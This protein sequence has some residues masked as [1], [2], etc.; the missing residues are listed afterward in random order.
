MNIRSILILIFTIVGNL[1]FGQERVLVVRISSD[2][3]KITTENMIDL[4]EN[5]TSL[6]VGSLEDGTGII[7]LDIDKKALETD[8]LEDYKIKTFPTRIKYNV[9]CKIAK[10]HQTLSAT[11]VQYNTVITKFNVQ[12]VPQLQYSHYNYLKQLKNIGS[13][14]FEGNY[15]NDDGG[16]LLIEGSIEAEVINADPTIRSGFIIPE[17][18]KAN[19][20][21]MKCD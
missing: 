12:Q 6:L 10:D 11:F 21:L 4:V 9:L 13:V 7:V 19:L 15:D 18:H 2:N 17:I 14:L 3:H 8:N 1:S 16:I 20:T 5:Q